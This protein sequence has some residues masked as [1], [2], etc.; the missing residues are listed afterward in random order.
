MRF[1]KKQAESSKTKNAFNS[2]YIESF[3][4][5]TNLNDFKL[6]MLQEILK[7]KQSVAAKIAFCLGASR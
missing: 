6:E 7:C 1:N 3:S 5:N 4:L 2:S